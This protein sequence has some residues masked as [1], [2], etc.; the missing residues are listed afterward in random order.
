MR[1]AVALSTSCTLQPVRSMP[2]LLR[3][4]VATDVALRERMKRICARLLRIESYRAGMFVGAVNDANKSLSNFI[5]D[6]CPQTKTPQ[7]SLRRFGR[8]FSAAIAGILP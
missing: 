1:M 2:P 6:A 8:R 5:E 3:T 7:I 4:P